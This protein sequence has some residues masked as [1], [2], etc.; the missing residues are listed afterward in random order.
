ML[1]FAQRPVPYAWKDSQGAGDG[2]WLCLELEVSWCLTQ[3]TA[4]VLLGLMIPADV[5]MLPCHF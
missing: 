1:G 2:L 4:A 3:K 5:V